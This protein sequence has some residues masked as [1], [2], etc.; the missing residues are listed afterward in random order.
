MSTSRRVG[1]SNDET[2][3]QILLD[4]TNAFLVVGGDGAETDCVKL[5]INTKQHHNLP[6]LNVGRC[7]TTAVKVGTKIFVFGGAE[8]ACGNNSHRS[9]ETLDMNDPTEW[10][11]LPDLLEPRDSLASAVL[12]ESIYVAGGRLNDEP[13]SSF[14]EFDIGSIQWIKH[15]NMLH[16]RSGFRMIAH[17][18]T[19]YCI[20]GSSQ[21]NHACEFYDFR[22]G[23]WQNMTRLK[24]GRWG[25]A[26]VLYDG[27]IYSIGG[28]NGQHPM[29]SVE[30]Y[31][32]TANKW[33]YAGSLNVGRA[34]HGACVV[35]GK[36]YAIGG[37]NSSGQTGSV[38]VFDPVSDSWSVFM[39]LDE[40]RY[41][42]AVVAV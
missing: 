37:Q 20:G 26:S 22:I 13:L 32:L 11:I 36:I 21:Q 34:F 25:L 14:D 40:P 42:G 38:E 24:K 18:N 17:Q 29:S 30:Y 12:G 16:T 6:S 5:D 27:K 3:S 9:C 31:D 35:G 28:W 39:D 19:L 1:I 7:E 2:S 23:Q 10:S 33:A 41:E 8:D 15:S 4:P